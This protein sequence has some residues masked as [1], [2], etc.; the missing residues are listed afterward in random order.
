[1]KSEPSEKKYSFETGPIRPPSEG[2]DFSLLLRVNRNCFWNRCKFCYGSPYNREPFSLRTV[3]ELKED[4]DAVNNISNVI[5]N[6]Q[7]LNK[8]TIPLENFVLVHNWLASG[9]RTVFLQDADA[10]VMKTSGLIEVL[11]YLKKNFPSIRRITTYTRS[12]TI[13]NK[14]EE[15]LKQLYQAGVTRLHAGLE[16]GDDEVLKQME[17]GVTSK[18]HILMG[19]KAKE[20]GFELSL[21]IIPGLGNKAL[22][23]QHAIN[24]AKILN[25]INPDFVRLRPLVPRIGTPLYED[26]IEGRFHLISP[27]ELLKEIELMINNLSITG[28]VCFDHIRNPFYS[29]AGGYVSLFKQDYNGYK[30]P[31]EKQKVLS[32]IKKGLSIEEERY[33]TIEELIEMEK[34][35][36]TIDEDKQ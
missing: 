33:M 23:K 36:Y 2:G 24:T 34:D 4:I 1:M 7:K 25:E 21:Y 3:K 9:A 30:F 11:Q 15:E 31:E 19:K 10:L 8:E 14:P 16:S 35:I 6:G 22:S 20:I 17:K 32:L 26:W 18:E 27:H 5:K 12:K 28:R 29:E 13:A